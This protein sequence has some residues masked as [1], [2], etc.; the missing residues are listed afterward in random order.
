MRKRLHRILLL[1]SVIAVA[2]GSTV[3]AASN[4]GE[5][6]LEYLQEEV[7][8]LEYLKEELGL[9]PGPGVDITREVITGWV[10]TFD[11]NYITEDAV[12][13]DMVGGTEIVGREEVGALLQWFWFDTFD[14][15]IEAVVNS[16]EYTI[17]DGDAAIVLTV[18]GTHQGEFAGVP[19][20]GNA[21]EFPKIV[22]YQ[23]ENAWPYRIERAEFYALI[24]ILMPQIAPEG[25]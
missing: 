20:T 14:A 17:G 2:A 23:L 3:S 9:L 1:V 4:F 16:V 5:Y 22:F 24:S 18:F 8:L 19:A 12:F 13:V 7:G 21:V 15:D 10:H 6:L 25:G 11:L